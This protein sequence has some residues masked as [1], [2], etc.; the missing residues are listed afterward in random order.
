MGTCVLGVGS[1]RGPA[2]LYERGRRVDRNRQDPVLRLSD[3]L[4]RDAD[5]GSRQRARDT[6]LTKSDETTAALRMQGGGFLLHSQFFSRA[7]RTMRS[8]SD[9]RYG[10]GKRRTPG[11]RRPWWKMA[12]SV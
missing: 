6:P 1:D 8:K 9:L 5:L 10:L 4:C 2:R 7:A 3:R 12:L 11:S